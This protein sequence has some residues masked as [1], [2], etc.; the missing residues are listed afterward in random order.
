[1]L[2]AAIERSDLRL[3]GFSVDVGLG[4]GSHGPADAETRAAVLAEA[5]ARGTEVERSWTANENASVPL[6]REAGRLSVR[7]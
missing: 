3:A 7:V 1:V 4:A 6:A 5:A 2:Q